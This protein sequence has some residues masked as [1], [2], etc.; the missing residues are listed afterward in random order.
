MTERNNSYHV[1]DIPQAVP[2]PM[3]VRSWHISEAT[4]RRWLRAKRIRGFKVCGSWLVPS[5]RSAVCSRAPVMQRS[6]PVSELI[7]SRQGSLDDE[8]RIAAGDPGAQP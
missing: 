3:L 5:T 2:A 4:L 8:I 7:S 6:N 1:V